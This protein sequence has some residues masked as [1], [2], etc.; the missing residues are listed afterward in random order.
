MNNSTTYSSFGYIFEGHTIV[1]RVIMLTGPC[2]GL[3]ITICSSIVLNTFLKELNSTIKILFN[4]LL[5]HNFIIFITAI[6]TVAYAIITDNQTTELCIIHYQTTIPSTMVNFES[7]NILSM[8]RYY[9]TWKTQNK[10]Y[11]SEFFMIGLSILCFVLEHLIHYPLG[12]VATKY[13]DLPSLVTMCNGTTQE[14]SMILICKYKSQILCKINT[15]T[16]QLV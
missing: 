16:Q 2:I 1:D 12:Y 3:I 10:E 13:F 5:V 14:G 15:I 6:S 7:M 9:L 4:L 8:I 11:A